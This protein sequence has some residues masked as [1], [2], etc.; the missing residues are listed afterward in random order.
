M[1]MRV[2]ELISLEV[3]LDVLAE[4]TRPSLSLEC[5]LVLSRLLKEMT[6]VFFK[7]FPL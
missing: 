1:D 3:P 5:S 6:R 2:I 7:A 4:I